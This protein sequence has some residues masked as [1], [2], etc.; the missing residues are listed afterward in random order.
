VKHFSERIGRISLAKSTGLSLERLGAVAAELVETEPRRTAARADARQFRKARRAKAGKGSAIA[1]LRSL[2]SSLALINLDL[3]TRFQKYLCWIV[4]NR[5]YS[6][7][8]DFILTLVE[9]IMIE[10][11]GCYKNARET[12]LWLPC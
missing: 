4:A 8:R 2:K 3:S 9:R 11:H 7:T 5:P 12:F 6:A 1:G 10:G